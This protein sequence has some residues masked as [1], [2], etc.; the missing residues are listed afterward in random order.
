M[1]VPGGKVVTRQMNVQLGLGDIAVQVVDGTV[2][3]KVEYVLDAFPETRD[4]T[5]RLCV[6]YW[7]EFDGLTSMVLRGTADQFLDWYVEHATS[8]SSIR[9]VAR[10]IQNT[11]GRFEPSPEER[12]RRDAAERQYRKEYGRT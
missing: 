1:D 10:K 12:R 3:D 6:R 5:K 2:Y 4:S 11:E 8:G 9:R 7:M